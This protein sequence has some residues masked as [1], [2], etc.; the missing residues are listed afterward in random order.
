[1]IDEILQ[2]VGLGMI[3]CGFVLAILGLCVLIVSVV[4]AETF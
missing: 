4:I 3:L 1:M 2:K